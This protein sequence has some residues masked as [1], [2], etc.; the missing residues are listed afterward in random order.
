[1]NSRDGL[2]VGSHERSRV[3]D[4]LRPAVEA[5]ETNAVRVNLAWLEQLEILS[6]GDSRC[7]RHLF[8]TTSGK[9]EISPRD[10]NRLLLF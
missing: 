10:M 4:V 6:S 5:D 2:A 1:M 3:V 9:P 7:G 8:V